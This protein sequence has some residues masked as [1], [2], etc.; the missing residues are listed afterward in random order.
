MT[1]A[2][3][4]PL[5]EEEVVIHVPK[6]TASH[7]RVVEADPADLTTEIT[8]QVSKKRKA[9]AVPVLGVIVK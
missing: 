9:A 8:V 1:G 2:T 5:K 3:R 6:G 7:V 4:T